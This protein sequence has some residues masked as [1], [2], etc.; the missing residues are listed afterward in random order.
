MTDDNWTQDAMAEWLEHRRTCIHEAGH[1]AAARYYGLAA[2]WVVY[3]NPTTEPHRQK[4]WAGTATA[5]ADRWTKRLDRAIGLAGVIATAL[6][7]D[8]FIQDWEIMEALEFGDIPLSD[9]DAEMAA[10]YKLKD[11][12]DCVFVVSRLMPQILRDV[13]G[14]EL[15]EE[16]VWVPSGGFSRTTIAVRTN[17]GALQL[18]TMDHEPALDATTASTHTSPPLA[19]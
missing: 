7:E 6:D 16:L 13:N 12:R 4:L 17:T 5:Y 3:P 1:A 18:I 19:A 15:P 10:G 11:V 8:P 14:R 9:N 2:E